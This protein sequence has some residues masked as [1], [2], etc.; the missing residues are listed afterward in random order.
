MPITDP[1]PQ[2][3][4]VLASG[5]GTILRAIIESGLDPALV[6]VDRR[7]PAE[8]VA[9]E[10]GV[11]VAVVERTSYGRDFDRESYTG[12]VVEA[13]KQAR[14]TT[15][16][17]AGFGTILGAS[18]F[19]AFPLRVLNTHPALLPSFKGWHAVPAALEAGVKITGCTVHIATEA[20]DDGPILAQEAVRV[21]PGDD[22]DSLHQRI[23]AVERELYPRTIRQFLEGEP[24]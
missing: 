1:A 23:K 20:V 14:V 15:V 21:L 18:L 7:C 3:L 11:P 4:G 6:I 19:Q 17:M 5:T 10:R 24:S 8:Q 2:V 9:S 13:L 12:R 16:A 22:E